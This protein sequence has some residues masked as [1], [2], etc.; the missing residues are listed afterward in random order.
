M[1][2]KTKKKTPKGKTKTHYSRKKP[3]KHRCGRCNKV[4]SGT[5]NDRAAKIKKLSASEKKP[6]RPYGGTLCSDC[7]EALLRYETRFNVKY[8]FEQYEDM[9]LKRDLTLERYLPTGWF[10]DLSKE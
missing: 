10:N 6:S 4:L 1:T 2:K 3:S 9:E 8:G 7:L 5:P